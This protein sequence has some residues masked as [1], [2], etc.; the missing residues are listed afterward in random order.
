M[1]QRV[2]QRLWL[3]LGCLAAAA[4]SDPEGPCGAGRCPEAPLAD[5]NECGDDGECPRLEELSQGCLGSHTEQR[6]TLCGFEFTR[7]DRGDFVDAYFDADGRLVA[8][9]VRGEEQRSCGWFGADLSGCVALGEVER[10]PC[11]DSP[12]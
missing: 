9:Q 8:V 12:E 5:S 11:Q 2:V 6:C 4:C 7:A 3:V 10:V 1:L